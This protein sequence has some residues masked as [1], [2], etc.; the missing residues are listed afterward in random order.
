MPTPTPAH[1]PR[2]SNAQPSPQLYSASRQSA[3]KIK[4]ATEQWVT[5]KGRQPT[6]AER[7]LLAFFT[8]PL[9]RES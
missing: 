5:L 9:S 1:K 2:G 7:G 6:A 4:K 3:R 8:F